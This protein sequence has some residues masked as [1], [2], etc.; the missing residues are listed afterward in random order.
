M[1]GVRHTN[2]G[3]YPGRLVLLNGRPV[4]EEG[5]GAPSHTPGLPRQDTVVLGGLLGVETVDVGEVP[6]P[7]GVEG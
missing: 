2:L 1:R 7:L 3:P 4:V 6:S 5:V